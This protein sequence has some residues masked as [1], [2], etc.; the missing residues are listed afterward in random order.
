M[1]RFRRFG[2]VKQSNADQEEGQIDYIFNNNFNQPN[3]DIQSNL[4]RVDIHGQSNYPNGIKGQFDRVENKFHG[5]NSPVPSFAKR[6]LP[7]KKV[8][9]P[10]HPYSDF[11]GNIIG[12]YGMRIKQLQIDTGCRLQIRGRKHNVSNRTEEM[13][14]RTRDSSADALHVLISLDHADGQ[15]QQKLDPEANLEAGLFHPT[16]NVNKLA[17]IQVQKPRVPGGQFF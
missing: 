17:P 13:L 4:R 6:N 1:N 11:V 3:Q 9:I 2:Y 8:Y 14:E 16:E 12:P 15:A 5:L 10:E 7:F